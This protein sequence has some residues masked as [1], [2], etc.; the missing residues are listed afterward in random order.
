MKKKIIICNPSTLR[1][2][3]LA[4]VNILPPYY[5]HKTWAL[6][7]FFSIIGNLNLLS[8]IINSWKQGIALQIKLYNVHNNFGNLKLKIQ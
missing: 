5:F 6:Y 3:F 8:L 2:I 1:R 7:I 4:Y